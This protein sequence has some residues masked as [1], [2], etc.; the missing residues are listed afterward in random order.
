MAK[1]F[2]DARATFKYL[3]RELTWEYRRIIPALGTSAIKAAFNDPG[4]SS[5]DTE[6]M[7]LSEIAFNGEIISA[8]LLN[9]PKHL[10]SVRAGQRI[11]LTPAEIE[12]WMYSIDDR[13]YGGFTIQLMRANMDTRERRA[14]DKAWGLMFPDPGRVDLVPAWGA[15]KKRGLL[16]KLLGGG[17]SERGD[18]D[19]EHPMSENMAAGLADAID[20]DRDRFL[21]TVDDDGL[22]T[23]HSMALAGSTAGVRVLLAKGADPRVKTKAGH[24][25]RHLAERMGWPSTI[26]ILKSAEGSP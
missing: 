5:D 11:E 18:P 25:A 9:D 23:L 8:E 4:R 14:H 22:T 17:D 6:H 12:D 7:W 21:K 10:T 16:K 3:W 24:T 26:E 2:A 15:R 19:A 1:A 20:E 13:V